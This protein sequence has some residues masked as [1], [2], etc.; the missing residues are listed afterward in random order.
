MGAAN[1]RALI[2][3]YTAAW[4]ENDRA[5]WLATFGSDATQEDPIGEGVRH[6]RDEIGEFWDRA[7]AGY[8]SLE[9]RPRS[10]HVAG[11]EAA[12]AWTIVAEDQAGWVT[13]DGVDVFT[14]TSEP[15][16]ASVRAFWERDNRVRLPTRDPD[17]RS[18]GS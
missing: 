12:L 6:G 8:R 3:R 1:I 17:V 14:F 10:I 2:L 4:G 11:N 9:I 16:I 18:T 5:G 7:M 13:F 15:R